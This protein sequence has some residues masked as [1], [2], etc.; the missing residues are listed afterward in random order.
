MAVSVLLNFANG[1]DLTPSDPMI[2]ILRA[3]AR[4]LSYDSLSVETFSRNDFER[5]K[6]I[7]RII[8]DM[9]NMLENRSLSMEDKGERIRLMVILDFT[10]WLF[11]KSVDSSDKFDASFPSLK[12]E[13]I[14]RT[15][16]E[17]F[18]RK[19]SLLNRFD[20]IFIFT[21]DSS[22]SERS[23]C[24]HFAAYHGLCINGVSNRWLCKDH[25][26]LNKL[27]DEIL[28]KM[29]SPDASLLLT[30]SDVQAVYSRFLT[31]LQDTIN[32]VR[33]YMCMIGR[34]KLFDAGIN[35][36]F[37]IKT[38]EEFKNTDYDNILLSLVREVA[39]IGS[40]KFRDCTCF[41][42][43]QRQTPASQQCFDGIVLKSLIQLLCTIDDNQFETQFRP[44][45]Q[46]DFHKLF[47]MSD[48]LSNHLRIDAL[49]Q[50]NNEIILQGIKL[51]GEEWDNP[52]RKLTGMMWKSDKEVEYFIYSPRESNV[53]GSH[54][55]SNEAIDTEGNEKEKKFK[56][57]RRIPFFFG[58]SPSDWSWYRRVLS[59]LNDCLKFED[60]HSRPLVEERKKLHDEDFPATKIS[61]NYGELGVAIH[62]MSTK[63]IESSVDYNAYLK[64]RENL[65]EELKELSENNLKF[66]MVKLGF[67]SRTVVISAVAT[68]IFTICYAFHFLYTKETALFSFIPLSILLFLV[69]LFIAAIIAQWKTKERIL[70]VYR[71]IDSVFYDMRMLAKNHLESVK[72]LVQKMNF[73]DADRKSMSEM[74][75]KYNEWA[76]HNKKVEVW[77]NHTR[78]LK[79]LIDDTLRYLD[80]K[81][82]YSENKKDISGI[83]DSVF[84]GKP[85]VFPQIWSKD[86]YTNM[87]PKILIAN[88]NKENTI[89]D[90]TSFVSYYE[91]VIVQK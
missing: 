42:L 18:G 15:I 51:G 63:Q 31:K 64:A 23:K 52:K 16:E 76:R 81:V 78:A 7:G 53:E 26:Q 49:L 40:S 11:L 10:P 57:D 60:G 44:S 25:I 34:E 65:I 66:E 88:Q 6:Q 82:D 86:F 29:K 91:F 58:V 1:I 72:D 5:E 79:Y 20:Y 46:N 47:I 17:T 3:G 37:D 62:N 74:K 70:D 22:D 83:D 9:W 80:I 13:Y 90:V 45:D 85:T 59:S 27:R 71:K 55:S 67:L 61:S 30:K 33:Q 24:Y 21:D 32:H 56:K 84:D 8:V 28:I 73:A 75:A 87:K 77:I 2:G 39:G 43:N 14:K 38:V 12:L 68:I 19:N 69:I 48:S 89:T 54:K 50:Y 35:S 36:L 4:P 41:I